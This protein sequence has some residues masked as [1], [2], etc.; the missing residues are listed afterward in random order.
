MKVLTLNIKG[1]ATFG[2]SDKRIKPQFV[3]ELIKQKAEVVVLTE[4][5]VIKGI[6]YLFEMFELNRYIYF[7]SSCSGKNGILIA[8]KSNLVDCKKLMNAVYKTNFISSNIEGCNILKVELPLK[9]SINLIVLGCRMET[10]LYNEDLKAQYDFERECFDNILIPTIKPL[11]K[12]CKYIICGD[13]NNAKC[14]GSLNKKFNSKDYINP[15]DNSCYAQYNYNLNII[16]DEFEKIGFEMVDKKENGYPI[17]TYNNFPIDHIFA[18]GFEII[19][20]EK[21]TI[22]TQFSDH[23]MLIGEIE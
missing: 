19:P 5:V 23:K 22:E 9:E 4:F 18:K 14:R 1:G 17:P 10:G 12:D 7:T 13:F 11:K 20:V 6:D 2:W 21:P 15:K 16:K 8:I 3:D